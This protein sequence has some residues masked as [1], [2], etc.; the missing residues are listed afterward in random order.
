[1]QSNQKSQFKKL[2]ATGKISKRFPQ[3]GWTQEMFDKDFACH[4]QRMLRI[5]GHV[6]ASLPRTLADPPPWLN[7]SPNASR[8]RA[9]RPLAR[10]EDRLVEFAKTT[11]EDWRRLAEDRILWSSLEADYVAFKNQDS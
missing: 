10:W 6:D 7:K 5:R 1:M 4:S 9:R 8:S 3:D 2:V 11:G